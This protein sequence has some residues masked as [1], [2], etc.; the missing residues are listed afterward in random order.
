MSEDNKN[1]VCPVELAGGLD[2]KIRRFLQNPRKIL[3]DYVM[4]GL[5]VLDIGCG[6]GVFSVAMAEMVGESGQVIA[7]DL[8]EGMLQKLCDKIKGTELEKR[9]ELHKC[10]ADKIGISKKV[11]FVL[12]FYVVH[13][14]PDHESLFREIRGLLKPNGKALIVEPNFHVSRKAFAE[15]INLAKN[16]GFEVIGTPKI[17]VSRSVALR[18]AA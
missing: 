16:L 1:C 12:A 11:D 8:Q 9:I 4:N 3:K 6:P 10:E 2:N 14:V 5:T 17:F 7:A 13:E 15:T 18:I